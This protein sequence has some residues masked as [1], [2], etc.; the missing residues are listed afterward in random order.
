MSR[1][2]DLQAT[3]IARE[4]ARIPFFRGCTHFDLE[5][6]ARDVTAVRLAPGET[7]VLGDL[8]P[9]GA[10]GRR[11]YV[12]ATGDVVLRGASSARLSAPQLLTGDHTPVASTRVEVLEARTDAALFALDAFALGELLRRSPSATHALRDELRLRDSSSSLPEWLVASPIAVAIPA[13]L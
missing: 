9:P 6:L 11:V 12:L 13:I 2:H 3:D 1:G 4:L 8:G 10:E 5:D 7:A